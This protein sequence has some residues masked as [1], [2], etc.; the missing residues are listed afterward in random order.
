[1]AKKVDTE[2][3]IQNAVK[4]HGDRYDYSNVIYTAAI[5]HVVIRCPLHGEFSQRPSNHLMGRGCPA[6]GGSKRVTTEEFISRSNLVHSNRYDYKDVVINNVEEKIKIICPIHGSFFQRPASHLKGFGCNKCGR[7]STGR[8]L[9]M[10]QKEFVD[11][12]TKL[13][14]GK[15]DY[16]FVTY[17]NALT[18]VT[19][20]CPRH[21]PFEQIPSAH[22]RGTGCPHCG[23]ERAAS[24]KLKTTQQF[25]DEARL[26]HGDK[27]DYSQ[28]RYEGSHQKVEISCVIHGKFYQ[29][30]MNHITG[31]GCPGCAQSGFDQTKPGILYY[32]AVTDNFG[33][34]LYKIGITNLSVSKRFSSEDK[35]RIT[36]LQQWSFDL[37]TDAALHEA[38]ILAM[39]KKD[40]YIGPNILTSAGNTELFTR[41]V[42][43]LDGTSSQIAFPVDYLEPFVAPKQIDLFH[44][45]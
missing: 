8:Q 26:A 29:N 21:G 11:L 14:G 41:D 10:T 33:E 24:L 16:S 13:H 34:K 17:L 27:Y 1:M 12:G 31:T 3:F 36:I 18:K 39:F 30:A 35:K 6:C 7:E 22:I 45:V 23:T 20:S 25:I 38:A 32:L 2:Q 28:S 9:K 44:E 37:G 42:L 15:Y 19:I 40:R 5:R 43:E 4:V